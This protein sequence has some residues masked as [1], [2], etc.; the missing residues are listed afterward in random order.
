MTDLTTWLLEQIAAD[1]QA[2]T[3]ELER[4]REWTAA[5]FGAGMTV[6]R[7]Q[8]SLGSPARVLAQC[9]AHKAIVE[10]YLYLVDHGDTTGYDHTLRALASI[11]AAAEGWD[12]RWA[13]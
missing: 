13:L 10:R 2:A 9:A 1:E 4:V 5:T 3:A 12:E 11:W 7:W 8:A 6:N